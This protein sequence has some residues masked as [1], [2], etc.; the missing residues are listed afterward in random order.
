MRDWRHAVLRQLGQPDLLATL[1]EAAE[2][3]GPDP[4]E[5]PP[6]YADLLS[7][8]DEDEEDEDMSSDTSS[9]AGTDGS[10]DDTEGGTSGASSGSG[11]SDSGS[12]GTNSD[13]DDDG[14]GGGGGGS[15][16]EGGRSSNLDGASGGEDGDED[17]GGV[18]PGWMAADL[19]D[20]IVLSD[21]DGDWDMQ[22]AHSSGIT[23]PGGSA[24]QRHSPVASVAATA[25]DGPTANASLGDAAGPSHSFDI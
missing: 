12:S 24:E 14:S 16:S 11:S 7:D 22:S 1:A 2:A 23:T 9:S 19:P 5:Q 25:D 10:D 13:D 8:L 21:S 15:D 3:V 6:L 20:V 4:E 17:A 18:H